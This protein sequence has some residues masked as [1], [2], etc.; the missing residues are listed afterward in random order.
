MGVWGFLTIAYMM[1]VCD[2]HDAKVSSQSRLPD[3]GKTTIPP[4]DMDQAQVIRAQ[5]HSPTKA[6]HV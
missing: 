2:A 3:P 1:P 6:R 4:G 5:T